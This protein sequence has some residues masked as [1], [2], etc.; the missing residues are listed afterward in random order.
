MP[1]KN[2]KTYAPEF[3]ESSA[4]LALE[5]KNTI[6]QTARELGVNVNTLHTWVQKYSDVKSANVAGD[7]NKLQEE[8]K[9]HKNVIFE[10]I[11]VFYNRIRSH[12]TN[13]YLSLVEHKNLQKIA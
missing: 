3:R 8:L 7:D 12:S 13:D 2:E 11:E 6:A 9:S 10:Y 1:D 4:K 5:S